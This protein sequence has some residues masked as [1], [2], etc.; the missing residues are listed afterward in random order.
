M[1]HCKE[2]DTNQVARQGQ[3]GFRADRSTEDQIGRLI[4]N[5]QDGWNASKPAK[6]TVATLYNFSRAYNKVW[7]ESLLTKLYKA[8]ILKCMIMW[9]KGFLYDRLARVKIR[10]T[11][12]PYRTFREGLPQG[13]VLAPTLFLVWISD[14][15]E[16]MPTE[17][18]KY[19]FADDLAITA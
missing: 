4:Q 7:K 8:Q 11:T 3:A 12:S 9:I 10:N 6:R 1:C 5:I 18:E 13:S 15:H 2:K 19:L 14:I 16:D 17:V